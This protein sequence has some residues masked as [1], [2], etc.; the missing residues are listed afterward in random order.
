MPRTS[1]ESPYAACIRV[2]PSYDPKYDVRHIEAFMRLEHPTLDALPMIQFEVEVK[3]AMREIDAVGE[4]Q[5]ER[6]A[7][8]FGFTLPSEWQTLPRT[9]TESQAYIDGVDDID[10]TVADNHCELCGEYESECTC[11][12]DDAAMDAA[13][14]VKGGE[15]E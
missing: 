2:A 14:S 6:L 12:D 8:S 7:Q 3:C 5:A 13:L 11:A 15:S 10:D 9:S 4:A 1:P